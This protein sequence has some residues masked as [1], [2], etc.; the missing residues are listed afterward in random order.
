MDNY[1]GFPSE[2]DP[3]GHGKLGN[4]Y[5]NNGF[6]R[7]T[8]HDEFNPEY[9]PEDPEWQ[10]DKSNFKDGKGPDVEGLE[11][12]KHRKQFDMAYNPYREKWM[13]KFGSKFGVN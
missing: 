13:K 1:R 6:D 8:W 12:S 3:E 10:L 11:L 4:L 9:Q 2:E 7:Q 5:R